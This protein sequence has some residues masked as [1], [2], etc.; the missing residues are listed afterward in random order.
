[1]ELSERDKASE[2]WRKLSAHFDELLIKAHKSN[3]KSISIELTA[4]IRGRI[5]LIRELQKLGENSPSP[6]TDR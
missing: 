5:K 2:L 3:E 1:M 6:V 4:N